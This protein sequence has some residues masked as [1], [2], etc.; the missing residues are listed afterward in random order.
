MTTL[1]LSPSQKCTLHVLDQN[2]KKLLKHIA[3]LARLFGLA[4]FT[5]GVLG[6]KPLLAPEYHEATTMMMLRR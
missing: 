5:S 4:P 3:D 1:I 6:V 2:Q